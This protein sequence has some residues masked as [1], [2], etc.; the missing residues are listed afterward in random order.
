MRC[1][2]VWSSFSSIHHKTIN[3]R[4]IMLISSRAADRTKPEND[5]LYQ[6]NAAVFIGTLRTLVR[7]TFYAESDNWDGNVLV[8][9]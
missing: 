8:F 4:A 2:V 6:E 5:E 7:R 3:Q 9:G 1:G